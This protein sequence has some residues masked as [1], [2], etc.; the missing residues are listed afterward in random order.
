MGTSRTNTLLPFG[1]LRGWAGDAADPD[2]ALLAYGMTVLNKT[3][4]IGIAYADGGLIELPNG[5]GRWRL[6]W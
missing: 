6:S 1:L 2:S 5:H 3:G 4:D